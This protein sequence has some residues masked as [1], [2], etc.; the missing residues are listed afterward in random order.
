MTERRA[1]G[2]LCFP[3]LILPLVRLAAVISFVLAAAWLSA[4]DLESALLRSRYPAETREE[5]RSIFAA[6]RREGI[7]EPLMLPRLEEGM[8]KRVSP[9]LLL[10]VLRREREG[11]LEARRLLLSV[12]GG[13]ALLADPASWARTANLLAGSWS[14]GVVRALASASRT[15]PEGYRDATSLY[16]S[17]VEWGLDAE[18]SLQLVRSLLISSLPAESFPGVLDLLIEG[19]RRRIDPEELAARIQGQLERVDS[20]RG[21]EER[22]Y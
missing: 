5:I 1:A 20:L 9:G 21:L 2:G 10:S 19:R 16:V 3:Q 4:E 6:A 7:P 18:V 13:K 22:I 14:P 8:A 15:R 12:E 11:L 17:L